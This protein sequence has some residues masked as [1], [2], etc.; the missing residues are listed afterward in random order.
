MLGSQGPVPALWGP[1]PDLGLQLLV[2]NRGGLLFCLIEDDT[3]TF[4]FVCCV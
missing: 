3:P 2:G 4:L 1:G